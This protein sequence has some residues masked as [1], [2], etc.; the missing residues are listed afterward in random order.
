M[1]RVKA[2]EDTPQRRER[3]GGPAPIPG[4]RLLLFLLAAI[5]VVAG[6][7]FYA[8]MTG[9]SQHVPLAKPGIG[10]VT[11]PVANGGGG[12]ATDPANVLDAGITK[13]IHDRA[14][15]EALR[16]RILEGWAA[17]PDPATAEAA[18][19]GRFA[20]APTGDG[21]QGK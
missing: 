18:K 20:P 11:D 12:A 5:V 9:G 6:I 16:K 8:G 2:A 17:S 14:V 19:E 3:R 1:R 21:G 15:R 7:V 4:K 10:F 13:T